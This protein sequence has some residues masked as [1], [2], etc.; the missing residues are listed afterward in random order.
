[1]KSPQFLKKLKLCQLAIALTLVAGIPTVS[2]QNKSL[3][4][5]GTAT[6][7]GGFPV[8]GDAFAKIVNASSTTLV[9]ETR[10][11]KGSIENIPL[12]EEGKLDI[13]LVA[14]EPAFEA[15]AG[16]NRPIA[17]LR[18]VAAMYATPGMFVV[19]GDSPYKTIADLKG[20]AIAFGARGSGLPILAR[21]VLDG[22]ALDQEKDF[23]AVYLDKAADG[24]VMLRDGRV[25]ALWGGGTGWPGFTTM[26]QEGGRF[27]A[28]TSDDI[29][30]IRAKHG[31]LGDLT[32]PANSYLGQPLAIRSVGSWSFVLASP[33]LDEATV[34]QLVRTLHLNEKAFAQ[35]LPQAR[36]TTALNTANAAYRIDL[37]HPGTLRYLKEIGLVK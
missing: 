31:Y 36:E 25:A 20:K 5:L 24:P 1:M 29:T 37:L 22:M 32:L 8:Y 35:L 17:N 2:A 33:K 11:T 19:R 14:G 4:I 9:I 13:A 6:P 3:L 10:N 7:G 26:M 16:I 28:P 34:Y 18:I 23:T 12:L 27:I 21:Y 15:L 30:Q